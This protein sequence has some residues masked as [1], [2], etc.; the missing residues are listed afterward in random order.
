M[1]LRTGCYS[2]PHFKI[3]VRVWQR[4]RTTF[5]QNQLSG[6]ERVKTRD[7]TRKGEFKGNR[8]GDGIWSRA[9]HYLLRARQR[10]FNDQKTFV[11]FLESERERG[12]GMERR[13][14]VM[15]RRRFVNAAGKGEA[16]GLA[17]NSVSHQPYGPPMTKVSFDTRP[18]GTDFG[19]HYFVCLAWHSSCCSREREGERG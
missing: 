5:K 4:P 6:V 18:Y 10:S 1:I 17:V 2:Q 19:S 7:S 14:F 8:T 3:L 12:E 9:Y 13:R 15:E 16:H 11:Q